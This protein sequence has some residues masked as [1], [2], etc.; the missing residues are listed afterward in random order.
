MHWLIPYASLTPAQ[1]DAVQMDTRSHKA[2]VG[3]P[4]AGKTLVLL[5]RLNLLF[6]RAGKNSDAVR[7]FVYTNTLKEFIRTGNDVLPVPDE[8]IL[9]FDKWCSDTYKT[10]VDERLPRQDR[11]PDFEA[12]RAGVFQAIESGKL[13]TPIF[14]YVLIDEAQDMDVGAIEMLKRIARHITVCM[15]GK[16]QLYDGRMSEPEALTRLGLSHHNTALLA[17]FRC[18]PMVTELAAQFIPDESRRQE[19]MRQASNVEMDRSRPLFY[20]A[21]NFTDEM[22]HMV[23]MVRLRLSYGDSIAV[24]FPQQRQVH[25]FAKGFTEAGIDVEVQK[26]GASIDFSNSLPKLMTYH[27]AKGLTFD[28]V[29]LPRLNQSSFQGKMSERIGHLCFVG[30]SR[31]VK[32]VYMSG[33]NQA[34][35]APMQELGQNTTRRFLETMISR[36]AVGL[37]GVERLG[38]IPE[39]VTDAFGL[40]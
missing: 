18:N 3:G 36:E 13:P 16:Q 12:I 32:W 39:T 2:I 38:G 1:Q 37:L 24:L 6:H 21:D 27:Q 15:D 23:E 30:V 19:F 5:H 20:V 28:S 11:M 29:F 10:H 9:T 17:A 26:L 4:G 40:D 33:K 7:L 34:L 14:D 35:I 22:A 8:C 31:A 25:G